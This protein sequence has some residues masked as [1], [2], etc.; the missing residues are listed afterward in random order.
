MFFKLSESESLK[1]FIDKLRIGTQRHVNLNRN[2]GLKL[3]SIEEVF[4]MVEI[5]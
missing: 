4:D 2:T 1:N 3:K 5:F